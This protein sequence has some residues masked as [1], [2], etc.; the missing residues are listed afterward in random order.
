MNKCSILDIT[1]RLST[2]KYKYKII[3]YNYGKNIKVGN[4]T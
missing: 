2:I 4:Q 1:H 3:V